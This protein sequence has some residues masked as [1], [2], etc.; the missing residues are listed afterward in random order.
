M[1]PPDGGVG[2]FQLIIVHSICDRCPRLEVCWARAEAM[3]WR[4]L[5]STGDGSN[6]EAQ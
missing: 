4:V 3:R 1:A 6:E 2:N 5:G